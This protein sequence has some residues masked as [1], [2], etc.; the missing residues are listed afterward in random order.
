MRRMRIAG[1][2][3]LVNRFQTHQAHQAPDPVTASALAFAAQL[4][5]HLPG[6][7]ER[8]LHEQFV[9]PPHQCQIRQGLALQAVI[10]RRTAKRE[11]AALPGDAQL[12]VG[13]LDHRFAFRGGTR[14]NPLAKKSRS[15]VS[16]PILACR[17]WTSAV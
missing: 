13:T 7:V 6:P 2:G 9:D 8:V 17:S 14:A 11:N 5:G 10:K 1:P 3:R 4:P 12:W 16:W 15:T